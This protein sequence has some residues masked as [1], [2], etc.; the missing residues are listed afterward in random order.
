MYCVD[1]TDTCIQKVI[2]YYAKNRYF[3]YNILS[4]LLSALKLPENKVLDNS[5]SNLNLQTDDRVFK[6]CYNYYSCGNS[7]IQTFILKHKGIIFSS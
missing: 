1:T 3:R 5:F 4:I 6:I 2:N 7:Y